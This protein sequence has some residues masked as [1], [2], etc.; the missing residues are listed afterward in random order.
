MVGRKCG[1]APTAVIDAIMCFKDNVVS[2]DEKGD[3]SKY[4]YKSIIN[5]SYNCSN[6]TTLQNVY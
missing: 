4:L 1:V 5:F 3:M 6:A 2:I